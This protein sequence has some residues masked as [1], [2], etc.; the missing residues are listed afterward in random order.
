M[1]GPVKPTPRQ[2]LHRAL[3][4]RSSTLTRLANR[5]AELVQEREKAR[6][7]LQDVIQ[8]ETGQPA[9]PNGDQAPAA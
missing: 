6:E 8:T 2:H 4:H 5:A 3:G 1:A 7:E 9:A